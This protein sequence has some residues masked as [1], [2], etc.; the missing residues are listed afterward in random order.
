VPAALLVFKKVSP[1]RTA[2][3]SAKR[4]NDRPLPV[5]ATPLSANAHAGLPEGKYWFWVV[6]RFVTGSVFRGDKLHCS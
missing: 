5:V 1:V 4:R 2:P 6:F 3:V